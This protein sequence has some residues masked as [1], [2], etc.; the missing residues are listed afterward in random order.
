MQQGRHRFHVMMPVNYIGES[1]NRIEIV[2]H[3]D[4]L[5]AKFLRQLTQ[6]RAVNDRHMPALLQPERKV[7][8]V[9]FKACALDAHK[10]GDQDFQ[11]RH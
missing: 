5:G 2:N 9:N 8:D 3:R 6:E 1:A 11:P 10:A 4:R 7:S